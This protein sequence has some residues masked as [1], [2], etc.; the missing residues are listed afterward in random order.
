MRVLL[1]GASGL[2]GKALA[3]AWKTD[4][5]IFATSKDADI[6]DF[7]EVWRLLGE[8]RPDWTIHTAAYTNVEA[9]ETNS[10]LA[11]DVNCR[12]AANVARAAK[13]HGSRLLYVSTDYVFDGSKSTPCETSDSVKPLCVYGR[14]KAAGEQQV[15]EVLPQACILRTSWLYGPHGKCF[16]NTILKLAQDGKTL[17]IVSDQRGCPTFNRD[18]AS[19]IIRLARE[20]AT[21]ILHATNAGDCSWFEFAQE[22]LQSA[23]LSEVTVVPISTEQANRRAA[24]PHYSVLSCTSLVELGLTMRPWQE[25]VSAYLQEYLAS[26][27]TRE[28][29]ETAPTRSW[30]SVSH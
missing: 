4:H 16:P 19:V 8:S 24:R 18:L 9:C 2:L 15:R 28:C 6:R 25:A 29:V 27:P 21:G 1:L 30:S 26:K 11:F 3:E 14:S 10:T 13:E 22:V 23:G 17:R 20:G 5:L 12:G 7:R